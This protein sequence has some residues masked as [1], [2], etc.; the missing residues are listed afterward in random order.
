MS[1][2]SDRLRTLRATKKVTQKQVALGMGTAERVY[3]G[4]ELAEG[5]PNLANLMKLADYFDVSTDYLLG[6]TDEPKWR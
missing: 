6:R 1:D 3:Q 5:E 4:Y 2:F